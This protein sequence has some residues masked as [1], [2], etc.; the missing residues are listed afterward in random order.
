MGSLGFYIGGGLFG[1]FGLTPVKFDLVPTQ[2]LP[3]IPLVLGAE[4]PLGVVWN[5]Q[6][7]PVDIFLEVAP[8]V[9]IL[10]GPFFAARGA[11]GFRFFF[12]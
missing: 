3:N 7:L 6:Q 11:V 10:P 5:F 9:A 12:F 4:V 8:G 1:G 2:F